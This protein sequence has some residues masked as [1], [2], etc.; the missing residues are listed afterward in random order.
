VYLVDFEIQEYIEKY[1]L[2][3]ECEHDN[4]ESIGYDLVSK[5]FTNSVGQETDRFELAP[6]DSVFVGAKECIR[7]PSDV[8][9]KVYLRNS[10]IRQGLTLDAPVYQPGHQT[11]VFFRITNVSEENF[12]LRAGDEIAMICFEKLDQAPKHQY[13]GEFQAE[14]DYTGLA[15][16]GK[17]YSQQMIEIDE[18]IT[19]L[20]D[21]EK[22]LYANVITLMTIFIGIFSL[23]NINLSAT[24][25]GWSAMQLIVCNAAVVGGISILVG[26]IRIVIP[27]LGKKKLSNWYWALPVICFGIAILL[28]IDW[29]AVLNVMF[30]YR[31]AV[32]PHVPK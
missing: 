26:L 8:I 21:L 2:L 22:S 28:A 16:Y 23:V 12:S 6:G 5:S 29:K 24:A 20:K 4:I 27:D 9:G 3:T 18:K 1:G 31:S 14:F 19:S 11:R 13:N 7:L 32:S 30:V 17:E 15:K 10:R 25:N